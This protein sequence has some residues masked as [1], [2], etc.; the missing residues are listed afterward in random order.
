MKYRIINFPEHRSAEFEE[1]KIN[2]LALDGYKLISVS[3]GRAYFESTITSAD[4][5]LM[6][7]K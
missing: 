4:R 6:E 7:D 5:I 2:E 1:E 3:E